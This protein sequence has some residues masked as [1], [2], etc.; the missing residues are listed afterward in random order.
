MIAHNTYLEIASGLGLLGLIP[1]LLIL[2]RGFNMPGKLISDSNMG[3]L[4]WGV[5]AA[6]LG[7]L[8]SLF[9]LSVPFKLDLWVM[10]ALASIFGKSSNND[11]K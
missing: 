11:S 7:M 8:T 2:Y 6:F 9:F 3:E 5:R 4:A 1:F 10:L